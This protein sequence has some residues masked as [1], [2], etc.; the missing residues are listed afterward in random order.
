MLFKFVKIR[1]FGEVFGKNTG[2][3]SSILV[4]VKI[5]DFGVVFGK[6]NGLWSSIR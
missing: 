6:N 4:F 2:V 5:R 1:A 3:L